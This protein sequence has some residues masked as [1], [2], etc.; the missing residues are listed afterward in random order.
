M[1]LV[2]FTQFVTPDGELPVLCVNGTD[3]KN[4]TGLSVC[5]TC[6]SSAVFTLNN[7]DA[8]SLSIAFVFELAPLPA[9]SAIVLPRLPSVDLR[10]R[11]P[12]HA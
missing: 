8:A 2:E 3:G 7:P 12:P 6:V 11:G 1:R 5:E 4:G 9:A 10:Q